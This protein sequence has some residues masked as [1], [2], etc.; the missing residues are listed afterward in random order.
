M[1]KDYEELEGKE[2]VYDNGLKT[3]GIVIGCNYDIGITIVEKGNKDQYLSCY[4]GPMA[5][6]TIKGQLSEKHWN[7]LFYSRVREI[8]KGYINI[9]KVKKIMSRIEGVEMGRSAN[10]SQCPFG[11]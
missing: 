2:V 9:S 5:P 8:K 11:Q 4:I 10:K 7:A 3:V 6:N 1:Q